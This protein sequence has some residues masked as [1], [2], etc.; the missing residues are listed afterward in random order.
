MSRTPAVQP[1]ARTVRL[2]IE[3]NGSGA[4]SYAYRVEDSGA[5]AE[6]ERNMFR[7]ATHQ[8]AQQVAASRLLQTGL[9]GSAQLHTSDV[10]TTEGPFTTTIQGTLEHFTWTDGTTALP[11][12]SSF[13][14]GI[15]SQVQSWLAEPQR[16]QPWV[17]VGGDFE[18]T[19]QISLPDTV[20]IT[21]LPV[22]AS[23]QDSFFDYASHYVFDPGTRVL[24]I[25][26][27]LHTK[28]AHQVCSADA[29][30]EA[31][32][33]LVR[34]ERDASSQVVVRAVKPVVPVYRFAQ[35]SRING[36]NANRY[37]RTLAPNSVSNKRP[38]QSAMP[39]APTNATSSA[40]SMSNG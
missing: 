38:S 6:L 34:I 10:T 35:P 14:G 24:Q 11:A 16:T 23:V 1:R 4:A 7:R 8:R 29:F 18:E 17:C 25:T 32:A 13:A 21:D 33:S 3:V 31:Q 39:V 30:N 36:A 37:S 40:P 9:H 26:R 15:A 12:L 22:D 27:H 20:R 2:Q 28:F 19:A 5:T